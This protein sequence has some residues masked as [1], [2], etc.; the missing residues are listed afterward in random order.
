MGDERLTCALQL[1]AKRAERAWFLSRVPTVPKHRS[2]LRSPGYRMDITDLS[3]ASSSRTASGAIGMESRYVRKHRAFT[4]PHIRPATEGGMQRV[5]DNP[6][7]D[8]KI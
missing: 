6:E 3:Y 7:R 4:K 1:T 2:F 8:R 5:E